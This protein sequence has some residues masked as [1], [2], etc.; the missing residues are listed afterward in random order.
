MKGGEILDHP[1][2]SYHF[3]YALCCGLT[4]FTKFILCREF[5]FSTW[6]EFD[7]Y[8]TVT[9]LVHKYLALSSRNVSEIGAFDPDFESVL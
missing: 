8:R 4:Y 5:W 3:A 7:G 1:V 6:C 9:Q 2:E